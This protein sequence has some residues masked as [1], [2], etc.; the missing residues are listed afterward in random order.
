MLSGVAKKKIL[1]L[2]LIE[3]LVE[4]RKR[5]TSARAMQGVPRGHHILENVQVDASNVGASRVLRSNI[6]ARQH[7]PILL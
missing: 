2:T 3:E 5:A 4:Q 7:H 1:G 6:L